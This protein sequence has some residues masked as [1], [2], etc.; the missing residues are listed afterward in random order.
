MKKCVYSLHLKL[1]ARDSFPKRTKKA[2]VCLAILFT[3]SSNSFGEIG[4]VIDVRFWHQFKE[5]IG[6]IDWVQF[7]ESRLIDAD[8][9]RV[10]NETLD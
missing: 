6:E 2:A 3:A 9:A 5:R 8:G 10:S 4:S 7:T 1:A